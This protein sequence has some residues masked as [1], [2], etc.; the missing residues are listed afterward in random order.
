MRSR[1]VAS[2]KALACGDAI[3]KQTE[4]LSREGVLQ[5]YPE[6]IRGFHGRAGDVIPRY[7]GNARYQWRIGET[8]DDTE[9]TIAVAR[10]LLG[11]GKAEHGE[12]GAALLQCRKSVHPGVASIWSLHQSGDP[13]RIAESGDG[14]GA[15]MRVAP[16]GM[17]YPTHRRS[18][19]IAGAYQASIPTHGGRLGVCAAAAVAMAVSAA[20]EGLTASVV[21]DLAVAAAREAELLPLPPSP[22]RM[23]EMIRDMYAAVTRERLDP[24]D[25]A[26]R[27]FPD[28][29]ET[30]VPLAISL[31]LITGSAA[32]TILLAANIGGDADS[33]ASIGGAIAGALDP[34]SVDES[35]FEVV[36]SVN[37][38]ELE[39]LGEGL[40]GRRALWGSPNRNDQVVGHM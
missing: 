28:R 8:T 20:I 37:G 7:R 18:E 13:A 19:L 1:A 24:D 32:E 30:K 27:Y 23:W 39:K 16:V 21:L 10:C 2:F 11:A 9:Q 25:L 17:L 22:R 6:G 14:C 5:W 15:G 31:A 33:V 35:W 38:H 4:T 29:P 3:G 26:Q 12:I 40:I 34:G 36:R